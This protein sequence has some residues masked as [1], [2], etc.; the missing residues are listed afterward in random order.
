MHTFIIW[1][2]VDWNA[3][4]INIFYLK[5]WVVRSLCLRTAGIG[6]EYNT[7]APVSLYNH[8]WHCLFAVSLYFYSPYACMRNS[9]MMIRVSHIIVFNDDGVVATMMSPPGTRPGGSH[10]NLSDHITLKV[11]APHWTPPP[12]IIITFYSR[13]NMIFSYRFAPGYNVTLYFPNPFIIIISFV[14]HQDVD[15]AYIMSF[16]HFH[17]I[18]NCN[19]LL[20]LFLFSSLKCFISLC[21]F[22]AVTGGIYLLH[23]CCMFLYIVYNLFCFF[24]A[25]LFF[26][27][28]IHAYTSEL[29]TWLAFL[30]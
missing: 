12:V 16:F 19:Y 5:G 25:V 1:P 22:I 27:N 14:F 4:I 20:C 17:F 9:V 10:L 3:A 18:H 11:T 29:S 2:E 30:F 23:A 13:G 6:I 7:T 15:I 28:W 8:Y 26:L 21:D 24:Q